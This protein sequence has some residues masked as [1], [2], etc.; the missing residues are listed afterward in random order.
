MNLSKQLCRSGLTVIADMI[1]RRRFG[2]ICAL[3]IA[4]ATAG[5]LDTIRTS[6][7]RLD[8]V[9]EDDASSGIVRHARGET[10]EI[11]AEEGDL[12][13]VD[14]D[15]EE[16]GS[17][18]GAVTIRDPNGNVLEDDRFTLTGFPRESIRFDAP[19]DGTYR[20]HVSPGN[21][22][23]TRLRVNVWTD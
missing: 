5:C 16:A 18:R 13:T 22:R 19:T 8:D 15:I 23:E 6:I 9:L 21:D 3:G 7:S 2:S 14:I 1:D 11:E 4:G 12:I 17:G 20:V 10:F